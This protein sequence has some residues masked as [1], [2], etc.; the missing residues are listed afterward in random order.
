[1]PESTAEKPTTPP[2]PEPVTS[3]TLK[4]SAQDGS[5]EPMRGGLSMADSKPSQTP[6]PPAPVTTTIEKKGSPKGGTEHR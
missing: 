2:P 3:V 5:A 6:P 1:M 4:R